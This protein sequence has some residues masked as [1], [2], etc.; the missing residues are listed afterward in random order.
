M[1]N[2]H[3]FSKHRAI[4]PIIATLGLIVIVIAGGSMTMVYTNE[5]MNTNKVIWAYPIEIAKVFGYDARDKTE[6]QIHNGL[7][8]ASNT[9]GISNGYLDRSERIGIYVQNDSVSNILIKELRFAGKVYEFS[10]AFE[11]DSYESNSSPAKGEYVILSRAP[12]KLISSNIPEFKGGQA[13]TI[14]LGLDSGFKTGRSVQF[15]ITTSYDYV[16]VVNLMLNNI[17]GAGSSLGFVIPIEEDAPPPDIEEEEPLIPCSSIP[18]TFEMDALGGPLAAGTV[19]STQ[20]H[21][22][23]IHISAVNNKAGH[24]NEVIIFDSNNPTGGDW[25]LGS[26]WDT[27]NLPSDTD[28][29]N[30]LIIA[31]DLVDSNGDGLVDDPDDEAKGGT[32]IFQSNNSCSTLDFDFIDFEENQGN[33]GYVIINLEGGGSLEFDFRDFVGPL[34]GDNS[35]NRVSISS[36]DIGGTFKQVEFHFIGSGAIDNVLLG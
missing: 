3:R 23:D 2:S 27:G 10:D 8:T 25:D 26:P 31:E 16:I 7:Y 9:A 13:A 11:L 33:S 22:F 17:R 36:E 29:G 24:P 14:I 20:W 19:V 12:D 18:I 1:V 35:A 15:K 32:I 21:L 5:F 4:A 6:L 28:L 30:L 34:Y